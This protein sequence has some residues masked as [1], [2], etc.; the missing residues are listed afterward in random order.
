MTFPSLCHHRKQFSAKWLLFQCFAKMAAG[1]IRSRIVAIANVNPYPI[2]FHSLY[3]IRYAVFSLCRRSD[4]WDEKIEGRSFQNELRLHNCFVDDYYDYKLEGECFCW[5][6]GIPRTQVWLVFWLIWQ[7]R[8]NLNDRYVAHVQSCPF[9]SFK[10][11]SI[12]PKRCLSWSRTKDMESGLRSLTILIIYPLNL[13][14]RKR[15][16]PEAIFMFFSFQ[17]VLQNP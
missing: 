4:C 10:L 12:S 8:F 14:M 2:T 11:A 3:L 13:H 17:R 5:D 7:H 9:V 1:R 16:M 15:Y 6:W